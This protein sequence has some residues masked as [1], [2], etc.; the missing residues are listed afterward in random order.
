MARSRT[1]DP[2]TPPDA[3][4][5]AGLLSRA[6][7]RDLV[8]LNR[9]YLELGLSL[10]GEADPLFAWTPSV[11]Q[12]IAAA[13]PAVRARMAECPFSLFRICLSGTAGSV[14]DGHRVED[15]GARAP[16]TGRTPG[17]LEFSSS[18]LFAA[19]RL[20]DSAPL[21]ARIVFGLT[22]S[23]ELLL[24]EL[25]PSQVGALAA[26]PAVVR[27]RWPD[28]VRFWSALRTA[29]ESATPAALQWAHCMGI[30]MID[31][32]P[33]TARGEDPGAAPGRR[34]R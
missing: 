23:E 28:R 14:P 16:A 11:R 33:D 6:V 24:N 26:D 4:A 31:G 9:N 32:G 30:C 25:S 27:A 7:R 3:S 13:E 18:A 2:R 20:A 10:A 21:A 34:R 19:W 15:H 12:E 1:D 5:D 8:D 29:A 17:C 22:P